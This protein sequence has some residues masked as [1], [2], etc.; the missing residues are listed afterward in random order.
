[1]GIDTVGTIK[2]LDE[3]GTKKQAYALLKQHPN[4]KTILKKQ[5]IIKGKYRTQ[6]LKFLAGKNTKETTHTENG[7][8]FKLNLEKCYFS[9]RSGNERLRIK[10]L[11][12][13]GEIILIMF[14]GISPFSIIIAKHTLAKQIDAIEVNPSCHKYAKENLKLNNITNINLYKGDVK[15]VLPTIKKKYDRIIMPLPKTAIEFLALAKKYIKS[16]GTIHLYAFAKENEFKDLKKQIKKII[17]KSKIKIIK[18]GTPK[19]YTFRVS[20]DINIS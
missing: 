20:A 2:I 16:K 13:P 6:K 9:P 5:G 4:I 12:K 19:P 7:C 15:K 8:K 14:D 1:M 17:P 11:V 18:A 10:N 3:K